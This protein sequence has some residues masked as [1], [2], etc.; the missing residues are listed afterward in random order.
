MVNAI[1]RQGKYGTLYLYAVK[2]TCTAYPQGFGESVWRCWAY[3]MDHAVDK[4]EESSV[5]EGC[6]VLRVARVPAEGG[7]HR[8][9]WVTL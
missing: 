2:Y 4:F 8:A 7:M 9:R 1:T 6:R 5:D 3:N